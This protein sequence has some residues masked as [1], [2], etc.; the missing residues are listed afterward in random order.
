M[1]NEI[2]FDRFLRQRILKDDW[3]NYLADDQMTLSRKKILE[4]CGFSRSTLYQ[5]KAIKNKLAS[6]E[7]MLRR[8]GVIKFI[9][10]TDEALEDLEAAFQFASKKLSDRLEDLECRSRLLSERIAAAKNIGIVSEN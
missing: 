3:V 6:C 9:S 7:N 5:N 2:E 8:N 1:N 10:K 4:S